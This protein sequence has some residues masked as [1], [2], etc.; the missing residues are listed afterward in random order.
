MRPP[1]FGTADEPDDEA[2]VALLRELDAPSDPGDRAPAQQAGM[3]PAL[4]ACGPL[5][6]PDAAA[7]VVGLDTQGARCGD[8]A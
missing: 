8:L 7:V 2:I 4:W 1:S 6:R 3:S 5:R